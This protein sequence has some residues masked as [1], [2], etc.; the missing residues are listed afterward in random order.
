MTNMN[1]DDT[2]SG[3]ACTI[4]RCTS[5]SRRNRLTITRGCDVQDGWVLAPADV[6]CKLFGACLSVVVIRYGRQTRK[7]KSFL[8]YLLVTFISTKR[9]QYRTLIGTMIFGPFTKCTG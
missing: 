9:P 2:H 6:A 8:K 1:E 5:L 4:T 3:M 7:A